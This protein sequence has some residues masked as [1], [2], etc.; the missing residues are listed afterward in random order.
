MYCKVEDSNDIEAVKTSISSDSSS[1]KV[2]EEKSTPNDSKHEAREAIGNFKKIS[3]SAKL[4]ISEHALDSSSLLAS[5]PFGTLLKSDVLAA[6][7][8]GKGRKSSTKE[9]GAPAAQKSPQPSTTPLP[10]S[11]SHLQQADSFEDLP[12]TQIRKVC[13]T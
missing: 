5:G 7:K 11:K 8:S 10:Q 13:A 9:K 4:L 2:K 12:N 3:P 6:I 1:K